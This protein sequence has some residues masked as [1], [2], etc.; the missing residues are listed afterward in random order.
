MR[1]TNHEDPHYAVFSRLPFTP[2]LNHVFP[3]ASPSSDYVVLFFPVTLR[4]RVSRAN[5]TTEKVVS[6]C[7]SALPLVD[8]KTVAYRGWGG[9]G[10]FKPP[11]IP[12]ISVKSSIAQARRTGVSISFYSSLCSHTVVIY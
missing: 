11:E 12:K 9:F 3:S 8:R 7:I 1:S 6:L 5:K 10:V 4:N 2:C